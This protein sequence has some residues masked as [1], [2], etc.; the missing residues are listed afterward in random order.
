MFSLID[1][2]LATKWKKIQMLIGEGLNERMPIDCSKKQQ[3]NKA[4]QVT[5]IDLAWVL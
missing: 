5:L 3:T 1:N 4:Y 2:W